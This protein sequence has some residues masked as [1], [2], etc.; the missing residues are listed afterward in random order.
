[1]SLKSIRESYS[2]F[3]NTLEDAGVKLNESQKT[4]LDGFILAIESKMQKQKEMAIRSTKK[5]VTEHLEK[6]F[7]QIFESI[8][9]HQAENAELAAKMQN[10]ITSIKESK[11]IARRVNDY[12][13]MYVESVLPKKTIVDYD[14]MQKLERLHESLKDMLVA[15][16]DAVQAKK[17]QLSESFAKDKKALETQIAKLQVKLNES[18][19]KTLKL[20]RKIDSFKAAEL[21]E[22]KTKD[23][24]T[25]EAR[26]VKKR[27]AGASTSEI[28]SKFSRILESVKDDMKVNEK[29][30]E[31]AIE[32]EVKDI[33]EGEDEEAVKENDM[34][35]GRKHNAHVAEA[36]DD[37]EGC[38]ESE[39]D[40]CKEAEDDEDYETTE[41]VKMN[42]DGDV[43][44]DE[45]E[46]IDQDLMK[47][48]CQ[49]FK[50]I[51][52]RKNH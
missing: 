26:Q 49:D 20:N 38:K 29:E 5:I 24:P 11:K 30:D 4:N 21:L 39:D 35:K 25:Y 17:Q 14:R 41:S 2:A 28:E 3:I 15:D 36:E 51:E 37:C 9:K 13:D 16:E 45:S 22:S 23:L 47:L 6:Q 42:E 33:I 18:M 8:M 43:E 31:V 19:E 52:A 10:K 34:L 1:M 27:L 32:E 7:K 44:L 46:V 40:E 12:L 48:W 50:R